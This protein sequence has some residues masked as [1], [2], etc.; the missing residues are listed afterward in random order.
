MYLDPCVSINCKYKPGQ[1]IRLDLII[2]Y[3]T[4]SFNMVSEVKESNDDLWTIFVVHILDKNSAYFKDICE[5]NPT[6][7]QF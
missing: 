3:S 2:K 1:N 6:F 4:S 5:Q 7:G